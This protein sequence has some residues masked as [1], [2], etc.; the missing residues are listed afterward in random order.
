M[1]GQDRWNAV[2]SA[3]LANHHKPDLQ[4][5]RVLYSAVA[6]HRLPGQP[7]WPMLVAPPGS[8]KTELLEALDGLQHVHLIDKITP[9]TF[10]SGQLEDEKNPRKVPASLLHRIGTDG[11]ICYPDF[12]T[13]I[14][15]HREN[16][17][18]ILADM[19]R[20]YDGH[21]RREFGTS[22]NLQERDWRGRITFLVA[23]TPDVD[24]YYSIF[25][26]LGERFIMVRY[27]RPG[28]IEAALRAMNQNREKTR[29]EL[30]EAVH[31]LFTT[32]QP[33]LPNLCPEMQNKIAALTEFVVRARTHVPRTGYHKDIIYLPEPEAATRLAQQLAQLAKGSALL[34]KRENV[35]DD[36]YLLVR[37]AAFDCIPVIRR[38]ILDTLIAGKEIDSLGLPASTL[39]YAREDLGTQD[40]V[41]NGKLSPSALELLEQAGI[42]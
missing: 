30:R 19:R 23:A 16:R 22:Q 18:T 40:L 24:R 37:R 33:I 5:A 10:I 6:A 11:I 35:I 26:A 12:S 3:L 34:E 4:A 20:I 17:A 8:L 27:P 28:G 15:M 21:L 13:V 7:V 14:S 38:K 41:S 32:L 39:S 42:L 36:D 9:N 1:A 29:R 31:A 25:Q 2:E